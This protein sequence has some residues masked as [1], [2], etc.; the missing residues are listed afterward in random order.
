M[1]EYE[2]TIID[3]TKPNAGRV[4]DYLIGGNHNFDVDRQM[5]NQLLKVAPYASDFAKLTRWFLRVG[6][7]R[8]VERGFTQFLDLASGLPTDDHIHKNTP[9]GTKVIYSDIDPITVEYGKEIIGENPNVKYIICDASK[10]E[11]LLESK[12]VKTLFGNNHKVAIGLNGICWFLKNE[13]IK[14]TMKI[15]FNWAAEGSMLFLTDYDSENLSAEIQAI[16]NLYNN[17]KQYI[18][19]RSKK[20]LFEFIKPWQIDE[21]G[22]LLLEEWIGITPTVSAATAAPGLR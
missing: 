14:H 13:Q 3:A 4:Y 21:P 6:I 17:M 16:F 19:A 12:T 15:L 2:D 18:G 9:D 5:A 22:I 11:V 8:A 10:P 1:A 7:Q 20:E